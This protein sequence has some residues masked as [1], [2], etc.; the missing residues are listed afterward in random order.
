MKRGMMA[1]FIFTGDEYINVAH[2]VSIETWPHT[3]TIWIR[4]DTGEKY[5]RRI[6]YLDGILIIL[7]IKTGST[8]KELPGN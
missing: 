1:Q 7:G 8:G 6:K 2:I 4:L 3:E 5:A